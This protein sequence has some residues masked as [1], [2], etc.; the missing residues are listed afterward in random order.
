MKVWLT[1]PLLAALALPVV[2]QDDDVNPAINGPAMAVECDDALRAARE[3]KKAKD[4]VRETLNYCATY[5]L[6]I[7]DTAAAASE[8]ALAGEKVCV[9]TSTR[10]DLLMSQARIIGERKRVGGTPSFATLV[11]E[12]I[13]ATYPCE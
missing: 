5:V 3:A 6:A 8:F 12:A 4:E 13:A 11:L 2:A 7:I 9:P 1:G 10:P